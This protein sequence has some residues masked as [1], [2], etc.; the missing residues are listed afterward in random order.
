MTMTLTELKAQAARV[1][2]EECALR[3]VKGFNLEGCQSLAEYNERLVMCGLE[4]AWRF[5]GENADQ[6]DELM[7]ACSVEAI[8]AFEALGRGEG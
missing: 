7:R 8:W 6:C 2:V 1:F 4:A 5:M 3:Q